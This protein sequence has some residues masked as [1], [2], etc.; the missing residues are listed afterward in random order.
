[1]HLARYSG[2]PCCPTL[3]LFC[4]YHS[5]QPKQLFARTT[6]PATKC[7]LFV[8]F[9]IDVFGLLKSASGSRIE[10]DRGHPAH[11]ARYSGEPCCPTLL[12]FC[13]CRSWNQSN[14]SPL[15]VPS[16]VV[17]GSVLGHIC[18]LIFFNDVP[19]SAKLGS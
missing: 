6:S 12:L 4:S 1:P 10:S 16:G 5:C 2:Q 9:F 15:L 7:Y 13:C 8:N 17:Q 3:L 11:F 18:F 19:K 14:F